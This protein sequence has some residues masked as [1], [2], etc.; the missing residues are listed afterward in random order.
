MGKSKLGP[1]FWGQWYRVDKDKHT[2]EKLREE[3]QT[4]GLQMELEVGER[5]IS[6]TSC[7]RRCNSSE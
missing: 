3:V 4:L 2:V 6:L 5:K 1:D 7:T